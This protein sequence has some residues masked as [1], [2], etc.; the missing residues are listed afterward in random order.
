MDQC[1]DVLHAVD[2]TCVK[3]EKYELDMQIW[4]LSTDKWLRMTHLG[5]CGVWERS[6]S[7]GNLKNHILGEEL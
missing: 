7:E 2:C 6:L 5:R 3:W 4:E 1:G